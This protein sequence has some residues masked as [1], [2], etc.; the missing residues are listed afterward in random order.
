MGLEIDEGEDK[1]DWHE[2][3]ETKNSVKGMNV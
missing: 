3:G 1:G 2:L